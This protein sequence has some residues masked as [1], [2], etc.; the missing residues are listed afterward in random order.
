MP[1]TPGEAQTL[2]CHFGSCLPWTTPGQSHELPNDAFK[3]TDVTFL[4]AE[5]VIIE[6][7]QRR[8]ERASSPLNPIPGRCPSQCQQ[9]GQG[10]SLRRPPPPQS[11]PSQSRRRKEVLARGGWDDKGPAFPRASAASVGCARP[12]FKR[13]GLQAPQS[14]AHLGE[15]TG[16][17][18]PSSKPSRLLRLRP[19]SIL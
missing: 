10:Q 11:H 8:T 17:R 15:L 4:L 2:T 12:L 1:R 13:S 14:R 5:A 6:S 9:A 18:V 3:G 7:P 16:L 19:S